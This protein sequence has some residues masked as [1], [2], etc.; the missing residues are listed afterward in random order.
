MHKYKL[1][2]LSRNSKLGGIPASITSSTS[3]PSNC[4]LNGNGCYAQSGPMLWAWRK[5]DAAGVDL[6]TFCASVRELP[7]HSLWRH[8]QAG[9]LPGQGQT[10]D[11]ASL[12]KLV[13]A[14]RG[15]KGFTYTHYSPELPDNAK[16]VKYANDHGFTVNLSAETLEQADRFADFGV[17]PVV[18]LLPADQVDNCQTP[19]GRT[20]VV[21]PASIGNTSCALCGLCQVADRKSVIGFPSHGSRKKSAEVIFHRKTEGGFTFA[22][23][24]P[25]MAQS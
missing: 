12:H 7:R 16:A 3:C 15:R 25:T 4:S 24:T 6:D 10:L 23:P 5:V 17:G 20:V 9:D 11:W 18:T 13:S 21:C 8:N 2:R 19:D 1:T 14:N 22:T